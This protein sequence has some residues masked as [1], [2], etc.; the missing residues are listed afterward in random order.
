MRGVAKR[1]Y[2]AALARNCR[3]F[4]QNPDDQA[5]FVGLGLVREPERAVLVS[6]SGV[7]LEHFAP[8]PPVLA[9]KYLL[10]AR[11]IGEKGVRDYAAA[12]E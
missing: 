6:G 10:A 7:D 5:L 3:I 2:R 11:L 9:P 8:A 1:L 4:F 12:A